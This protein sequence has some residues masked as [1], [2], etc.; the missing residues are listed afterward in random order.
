MDTPKRKILIVDDN[1]DLAQFVSKFLEEHYWTSIVPDGKTAIQKVF[2]E[3]PDL[4]LLDLKLPDIPGMEVLK[5]I[6]EMNEETAVIVMTA[7][8]GEQL[9]VGLMKAGAVDY[10]SKPFD[11]ENLLGAVHNALKIRDAQIEDKRKEIYLS[12][13]RF[14][15]FLAHEVRNPLHAIDGALAIIQRR[16]D[17]KDKLLLQSVKVIKEE[18]QHLNQFVQECLDFVRPPLRG[19]LAEIEINEVLSVVINMI[20]HIFQE[21]SGKI[22][23]T[24]DFNPGLPKIVA[25][26]EEIKQAFLN[27]LKN[28]F[29]AMAEGGELSIKTRFESTPD[30]GTIEVVFSDHGKGI[31]KE[32]MK[33]LFEPFFTTKL[34]GTGLGLAICRR[35]I[36]ERHGGRIGIESE[37]G[38]GTTVKVELPVRREE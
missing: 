38:K 15:P 17:S 32:N 3:S 9:A 28:G 37:A 14:F 13:E 20:S 6:K 27:I 10:L 30:L 1:P 25:S 34:R 29:E 12:L 23:I 33:D 36:E 7:Y 5:K 18:V 8:G 26:Y 11:E 24:T 31:E 16:S 2:S 19:R 35:I 22:R 21:V 4:V